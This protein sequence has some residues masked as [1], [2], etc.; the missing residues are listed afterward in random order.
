MITSSSILKSSIIK[1]LMNLNSFNYLEKTSM[2]INRI[3]DIIDN[4]IIIIIGIIISII[5]IHFSIIIPILDCNRLNFKILFKCIFI[6]FYN[7]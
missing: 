4:T 6:I 2:I 3:I 7:S 5:L 1:N